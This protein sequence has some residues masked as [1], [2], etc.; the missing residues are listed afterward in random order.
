MVKNLL[1]STLRRRF[2]KS[3]TD[4]AATIKCGRRFH[5]SITRLLQKVM[6]K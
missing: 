3:L 4:D 2:L 5:A 1:K 6:Q